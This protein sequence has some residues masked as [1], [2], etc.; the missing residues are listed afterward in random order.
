MKNLLAIAIV[1]RNLFLSASAFSQESAM[2]CALETPGG[3]A[4][5]FVLHGSLTLVLFVLFLKWASRAKGG[6][7]ATETE[8]TSVVKEFKEAA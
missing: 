3:S 5:G 2:L 4:L 8:T 1:L 7:I 6:F